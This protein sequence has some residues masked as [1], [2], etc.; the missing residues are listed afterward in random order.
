MKAGALGPCRVH[1]LRRVP[2]G[3][4]RGP[5][6]V[7][8][9]Y[10]TWWPNCWIVRRVRVSSP[11]ASGSEFRGWST[12]PASGATRSRSVARPSSAPAPRGEARPAG[13][14][15]ARRQG[16]RRRRGELRC[17]GRAG[18]VA[19]PSDRHRHLGGDRSPRHRRSRRRVPGGRA[20]AGA[21]CRPLVGARDGAGPLVTLEMTS[22]ARAIAERYVRAA[23]EP[24]DGVTAGAVGE[25]DDP[26]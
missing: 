24:I 16:R 3:R 13:S 2:T 17:R 22:S 23:G 9:T 21:G 1:E 5:D 10:T 8:G 25:A 19:V 18:D 26:R 7:L 12:T 14:R 11:W 15:R 6:A 20:R 4:E